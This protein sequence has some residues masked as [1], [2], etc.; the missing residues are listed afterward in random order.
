M[1]P[2][3]ETSAD[4]STSDQPSDSGQED[5]M[6]GE[7]FLVPKSAVKGYEVGQT[8]TFRIAHLY[9]D[10]AEL[11]PVSEKEEASPDDETMEGAMNDL[12]SRATNQMT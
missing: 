12:D 8:C 10:E 3:D 5:K 4:K 11:E 1:Y 6:E 7:T 9:S 2:T